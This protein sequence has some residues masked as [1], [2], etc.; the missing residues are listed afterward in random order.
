[1]PQDPHPA[2]NTREGEGGW[3]L[4][5]LLLLAPNPSTYQQPVARTAKTGRRQIEARPAKNTKLAKMTL[6]TTGA[7]PNPE[8]N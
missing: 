1:M 5:L 4:L 2:L 6:S 7:A 3:L 8:K